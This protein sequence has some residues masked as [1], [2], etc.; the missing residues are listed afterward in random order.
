MKCIAHR[1]WSSKAPENTLAAFRL[2]MEETWIYGVELDVHL[3][4]DGVPVVI[5][6]HTL[7]RTTNGNGF[8]K[9]SMYEELRKLDA[10]SWFHSSFAEEKIPSLEEVFQLF[11]PTSCQIVVELK[12]TG[13]FYLGLEKAVIELIE[14]Y[15]MYSQVLVASFDHESVRMVKE[16]DRHVE[17]GFIVLG[18]PTMLID[19]LN[20]TGAT[21]VSMHYA[22]LTKALVST[23]LEN[24]VRVGAWTVDDAKV[25]ETLKDYSPHMHITTNKPEQFLKVSV[26]SS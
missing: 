6:D 9:E 26:A 17:T 12:Q 25:M 23:L 15:N 7:E 8:I 24:G 22:Y 19:Q 21:S 1:G 11:K 3:T 2:A 13:D 10:G 18:Q 5:H 16:L 14:K 4:K 20:F